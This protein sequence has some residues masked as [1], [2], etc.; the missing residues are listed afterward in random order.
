MFACQAPI[1]R[2]TGRTHTLPQRSMFPV[3]CQKE[4]DS[5]DLSEPSILSF[6]L[7]WREP[8]RV[9]NLT[10]ERNL[11]PGKL[12][13]TDRQKRVPPAAPR[14]GWYIRRIWRLVQRSLEIRLAD[15]GLSVPQY[16]ILRELWS[17]DGTTQREM[18]ARIGISAAS[19]VPI[20]DSLQKR[21]FLKRV[22][23]REDRRKI[24]VVL[25]PLGR[26]SEKMLGPVGHAVGDI[27]LGNLGRINKEAFYDCLDRIIIELENDRGGDPR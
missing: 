5:G 11:S 4:A 3:L 1:Q 8:R 16:M 7:D 24:N 25:T 23:N 17:D 21:G 9:L 15:V 12:K 18:A 22:P 20:I 6:S 14:F 13:A 27:A 19:V 10:R 2:G 26:D